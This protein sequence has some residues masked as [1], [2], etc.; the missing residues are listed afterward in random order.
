MEV[1]DPESPDKYFTAPDRRWTLQANCKGDS[2]EMFFPT[3]GGSL[4]AARKRCNECSVKS[5]CLEYALKVS[6]TEQVTGFW[7]GTTEKERIAILRD[8]SVT[9][10]KTR[11]IRAGF[12]RGA[13][14]ESLPPPE[15]F[16]VESA[17][18]G[19]YSSF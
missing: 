2:A 5:E 15:N 16:V 6:E 9:R 14:A 1:D 19:R 3:R 8:R 17:T 13:G 18:N 4:E 11:S 10:K 7:A 12:K